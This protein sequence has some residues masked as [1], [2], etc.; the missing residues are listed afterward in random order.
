MAKPKPKA[1]S[2]SRRQLEE[3]LI[4]RALEDRRFRRELLRRPRAVVAREIERLTGRRNALPAGLRIQVNEESVHCMQLTLPFD[5]NIFAQ[6][7]SDLV[8]FWVRAFR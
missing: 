2:V 8:A 7:E 3:H 5:F 4:A 1:R 6:A